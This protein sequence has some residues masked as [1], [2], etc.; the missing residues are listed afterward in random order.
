MKK[1]K[2]EVVKPRVILGGSSRSDLKKEA[3]RWAKEAKRE[4][5]LWRKYF[6]MSK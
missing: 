1:V 4:S 2:K 5:Q 6:A 3:L